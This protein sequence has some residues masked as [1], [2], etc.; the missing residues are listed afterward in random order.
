[1]IQ[2][3]RLI[4][5][6]VFFCAQGGF[7]E[8]FINL[9]NNNN[10]VLWNVKNDGV[11][12]YACTTIKDFKRINIAAENSGME[13]NEVKEKGLKA[14]IKCHKY[15]CGLCLGAFIASLVIVFLSGSLWEIEI[16][17]T[18]GV[19]VESFTESLEELGVKKGARKSK[20]DILDVQEK[21]L[22]KHKELLWV[23]VNIFG[24]KAQIEISTVTQQ[25]ETI[26]KNTPTNIVA[27]K[28]GIITLVKGYYGVNVVKEGDNVVE[29]SLLI[30]GVGKYADGNEYFTHAKGEV[31]AKTNNETLKTVNRKFKT[32]ITTDGKSIYGLDVFSLQIPFGKIENN[33]FRTYSSVDLRSGETQLPLGVYRVDTYK[34]KQTD[35]N[36]TDDESLLYCLCQIVLQK[37]IDYE[38]AE[39]LNAEYSFETDKQS[40]CLKQKISCIENIA[41]EQPLNVENN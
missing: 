38:N 25:K 5:G 9:C 12:V 28:D 1:M 36:F 29:G 26:D 40:F 6:Y 23:S 32:H 27:Q 4:K 22:D 2:I 16:V 11:K 33:S 31:F 10:I 7:S 39:I 24:S 20:I 30:S 17:S 14:F 13:I 15:R 35:I 3:L 37:R 18:N 34:T 21:L 8:R 19:N 41:V